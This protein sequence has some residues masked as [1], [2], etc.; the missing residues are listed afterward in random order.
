MSD[1]ASIAAALVELTQRWGDNALHFTGPVNEEEIDLAEAAL[2]VG[3]PHSYRVFLRHFGS[4]SIWYY[5]LLGIRSDSLWGDVV[6]LNQLAHP[7]L[8]RRYL[9]FTATIGGYTFYF[10]TAQRDANGECPVVVFGPG[11]NGRSVAPSFLSFLK[12][13]SSGLRVPHPSLRRGPGKTSRSQCS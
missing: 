6:A 8:P 4:G 5:T 10:D 3:F 9:Q 12:Q 7:R 2:G 13:I 1:E 11:A